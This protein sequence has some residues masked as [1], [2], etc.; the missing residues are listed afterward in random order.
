[1]RYVLHNKYAAL[2][3]LVPS[4]GGMVMSVYFSSP[5][6]A[7]QLPGGR[8]RQEKLMLWDNTYLCQRSILLPPSHPVPCTMGTVT[9]GGG[10]TL[11]G[12]C[13]I[14]SVFIKRRRTA[15]EEQGKSTSTALL[16]YVFIIVAT[17]GALCFVAA[18]AVMVATERVL[19]FILSRWLTVIQN[20][21][22]TH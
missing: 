9:S 17:R 13:A 22:K 10:C 16:I 11:G 14:S 6:R 5:L 19:I 15:R 7:V 2:R 4:C 18:G 12:G 20:A 8:R 3:D 21:H 1:M